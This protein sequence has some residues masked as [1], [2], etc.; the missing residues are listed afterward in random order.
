MNLTG[1]IVAIGATSQVTEK[2]R[3]RDLVV[4]YSENPTYPQVIK[5]E[6]VNDKCDTLNNLAIG[7]EVDVHFNLNG[8][9]WIN[10]QGEKQYFNTLQV[11]KVD[12]LSGAAVPENNTGSSGDGSDLPF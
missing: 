7:Q 1:T 6:A 9:E 2:L 8:R 4:Q 3:K 5:F 12:V 10:K 11:W